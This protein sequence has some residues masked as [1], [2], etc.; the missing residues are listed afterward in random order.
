MKDEK[1]REN[2]VQA[3]LEGES[4]D[5]VK[6][7]IVRQEPIEVEPVRISPVGHLEAEREKLERT[8]ENLQR[9]LEVLDKLINDEK[10]KIKE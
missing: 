7:R 2:A 4:S 1:K 5:S 6:T 3:F 10:N 8:I 9:K